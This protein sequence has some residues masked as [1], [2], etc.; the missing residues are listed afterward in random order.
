[1][2]KMTKRA[3]IYKLIKIV[4][5]SCLLVTSFYIGF[6][7]SRNNLSE[8]WEHSSP[9]NATTDRGVI[10]INSDAEFTAINGVISGEG[11]ETD[12]YVIANWNIVGTYSQPCIQIRDTSLFFII[13]DC[14]ISN[15]ENNGGI[16]LI[17]LQ[18]G[19][20][21][22]NTVYDS[23]YGITCDQVNNV[24]ISGNHCYNGAD[25]GISAI[26]SEN[27]LINDNNV[28]ENQRWGIMLVDCN[29]CSVIDNFAN[30]NL[31]DGIRLCPGFSC[32]IQN[33][34][35]NNNNDYG[36]ILY[37]SEDNILTGNNC[38][39]NDGYGIVFI[40][41]SQD[42]Q[43][44][45]NFLFGN[46]D[47]CIFDE[48]GL[49]EC[50][51]NFCSEGDL[52]A[53]FSVARTSVKVDE[54]INFIDLSTGGFSVLEYY[55]DFGDGEFS[56]HKDPSHSYEE[57]GEKIVTLLVQDDMGSSSSFSK[58]ISVMEEEPLI[59]NEEEPLINN[60][61][62]A[63]VLKEINGYPFIALWIMLMTPLV[64]LILK[65]NHKRKKRAENT[66]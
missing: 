22:N 60:D 56:R 55:W 33:N 24:N 30:N 20:L 9:K 36:I 7:F 2:M 26:D 19:V 38:S 66:F 43:V 42:N 58:T 37:Y 1:M 12:P 65:T 35:C 25:L 3:T 44:Y 49:N 31:W 17:T 6:N 8:G 53:Y 61:P 23:L 16:R 64:V 50:F 40:F 47:G 10:V 32:L 28:Y 11:S 15:G 62:F 34:T 57:I 18:N 29:S 13:K 27:V 51:D 14:V 48:G 45:D 54:V 59:N 4:F 41:E 52:N 39:F 46:G 5:F 21:M 63:D